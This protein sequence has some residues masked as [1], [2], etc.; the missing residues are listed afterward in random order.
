MA[1]WANHTP[2]IQVMPH[3][4]VLPSKTC[5]TLG[6]GIKC[7]WWHGKISR[8]INWSVWTITVNHC[9]ETNSCAAA[10]GFFVLNTLLSGKYFT[11]FENDS[12]QNLIATLTCALE[13]NGVKDQHTGKRR[14]KY[15]EILCAYKSD[16][17]VLA[18][19]STLIPHNPE[20]SKKRWCYRVILS[21]VNLNTQELYY[22]A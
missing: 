17:M 20:I 6:S 8:S 22:H 2:V 13:V 18:E 3:L 11:Y 5:N 15:G 10:N 9:S 14:E 12:K 21:S 16:H 19:T 4:G 1:H 7:V